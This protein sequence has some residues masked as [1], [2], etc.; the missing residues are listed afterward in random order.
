MFDEPVAQVPPLRLGEPGGQVS[1]DSGWVGRFG[2][3]EAKGQA[4]DVGIDDDSRGDPQGVAKHDMGRLSPDSGQGCQVFQVGR[5]LAPVP[6]DQ[7]L[8][9][10]QQVAGFGPEEACG[11]DQALQFRKLGTGQRGGVGEVI[12]KQRRDLIDPGVGTLRRED[13]CHQ[14]LERVSKG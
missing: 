10:A 2:P 12:E 7:S 14:Q 5:H 6:S 4:F 13:R 3:P 8:S 9:H 1:L 11:V